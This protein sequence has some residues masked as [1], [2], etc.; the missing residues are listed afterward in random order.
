MENIEIHK[1]I[2]LPENIVRDSNRKGVCKYP[3]LKMEI[4]DSFLMLSDDKGKDRIVRNLST[5]WRAEMKRKGIKDRYF[6]V[7]R[8]E[9]GVRIWRIK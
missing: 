5:A 4:N 1:N 7:R 8:V 9:E 2:P 6:T 3:F